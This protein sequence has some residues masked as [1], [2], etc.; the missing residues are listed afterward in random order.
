MLDW[1]NNEFGRVAFALN[2]KTRAKLLKQLGKHNDNLEKLLQSS[3]RIDLSISRRISRIPER[4][5]PLC[6]QACR[7]HHTLTNG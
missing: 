7:L 2:K 1:W 5:R 3:D 6:K 4:L